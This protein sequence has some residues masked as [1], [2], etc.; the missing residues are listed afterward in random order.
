MTNEPRVL[1]AGVQKGGT[2]ALFEYLREHPSLLLPSIKEAH[3]FDDESIDWERPNYDRYHACF[4]PPADGHPRLWG[5]VTPIYLYWPYCLERIAAYN[6]AMKLIL[7]FR[8]PVERAW[9]HWKMEY[10]RGVETQPFAW[11]IREGRVRVGEDLTV[12]GHHREFSY[13]ERGFYG[14]QTQRLLNVFPREQV[15]LLR[16]DELRGAPERILGRVC[17]FLTAP[18]FPNVQLKESHIGKAIDY[19]INIS[20]EDIIYLRE[21]FSEDSLVF[22]K[23]TGIEFQ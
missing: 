3:F 12:P 20:Q 17:D 9:S 7:I 19:G 18:H 2:T 8:D 4:E 6:P 21:L 15:L 14:A 11:C 13:V 16:S 10:A 5:E 1:V 23:L 22:S